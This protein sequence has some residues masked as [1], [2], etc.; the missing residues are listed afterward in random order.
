MAFSRLII[1]RIYNEY[2]RQHPN[3]INAVIYG[4]GDAGLITFNALYQDTSHQYLIKSFIDDSSAKIG[5]TING[6]PI[7]NRPLF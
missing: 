2:F 7:K 1:R 4:A 6:I 5:K 3:I